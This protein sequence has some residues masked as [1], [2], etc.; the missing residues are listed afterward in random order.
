MPIPPRLKPG[1]IDIL[2]LSGQDATRDDY[3]K[4][5]THPGNGSSKSPVLKTIY[6]LLK[7]WAPEGR[8][9]FD[10]NDM[11]ALPVAEIMS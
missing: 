2:P 7:S 4:L 9:Y 10:G 6:G 5:W 3:H 1:V 8:G 11:T